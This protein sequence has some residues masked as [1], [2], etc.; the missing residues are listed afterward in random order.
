MSTLRATFEEQFEHTWLHS[1]EADMRPADR[2]VWLNQTLQ[3]AQEAGI[4]LIHRETENGVEFAFYDENNWTAF[5][6]NLTA[7]DGGHHRHTQRFDSPELQNAWTALAASYL[8]QAGIQYETER[9]FHDETVF[10]F[11]KLSDRAILNQLIEK[12]VLDEG[13]NTL[14]QIR[15]FQDRIAGLDGPQPEA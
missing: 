3:M 13:A 2:R 4:A 12:G 14:L 9:R 1:F 8:D 10:H 7:N 15:R 6:L 5:A 11:E